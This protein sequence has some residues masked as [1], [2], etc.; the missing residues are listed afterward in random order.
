MLKAKYQAFASLKKWKIWL[1]TRQI[2]MLKPLRT[3]NGL[4]FC[5]S[6]FEE[7]CRSYGIL[8]H[9][10]TKQT[11]QNGIAERVNRNPLNKIKCVLISSG[12][13]VCSLF[14]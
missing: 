1:R 7:L 3:K 10:I 11:Q 13:N 2:S 6:K 12:F 14:G 5:N 4:E 8:R 9:R